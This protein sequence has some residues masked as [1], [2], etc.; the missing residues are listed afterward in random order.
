MGS[1]ILGHR[2]GG[3]SLEQ[4]WA[5]GQKR[6]KT[7]HTGDCCKTLDWWV[8]T[9]MTGDT[10][11]EEMAGFNPTIFQA[12]LLEGA[13]ATKAATGRSSSW[14]KNSTITSFSKLL[15][16]ALRDHHRMLTAQN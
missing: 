7:L 10:N 4:N 8:R 1:G 6:E 12:A 16:V 13:E 9:A 2:C 11:F 15:E 3:T 5:P 14:P